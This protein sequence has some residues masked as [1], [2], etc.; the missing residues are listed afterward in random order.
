MAEE[1]DSASKTEEPTQKRLDDAR[2]KGQ[3]AKSIELTSFG[4]LSG[5]FAALAM[6]GTWLTQNLVQN[7]R[8]FIANAGDMMLNGQG[9]QLVAFEAIKAALPPVV[10]VMAAAS[11]C[12][13]AMTLIQTGLVFSADP[14]AP[15][16]EK[17]S[18]FAGFGRMFG[19]QGLM[20][21]LRSFLKLLATAAVGWW[22]LQP[23]VDKIPQMSAMDM[24]TVLLTSL[25]I[26]KRLIIGVLILLA[27]VGGLDFLWQRQQFMSKMRMTREEMKEEFKQSDGDPHIKARQRQIRMER[28]RRRMMQ[29]VPEA[30][31]VVMNP[32]HYAVALKYEQGEAAAPTCVAKGLDAVALRIREVAED[33]NVPII[34]DPPLA[35]ALY[36]SVE[37]DEQIPAQHFE[38]VAKIIGFILSQGERRAAR[39]LR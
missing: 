19:P 35:R 14:I 23:E 33:A 34:E 29:A 22:V 25:D 10:L 13:V 1:N 12:G 11:I 15:K 8:P 5:A 7:L 39:N 2:K 26:S 6:G 20:Q 38:A 28:A 4:S 37:I 31:V 18:P 36:A 27:T 30:T 3:V 21:F 9:G 24:V 32:T 17:V 16:F